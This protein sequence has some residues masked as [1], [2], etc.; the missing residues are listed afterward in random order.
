MWSLF[1]TVLL[2]A[3][4][5]C[6]VVPF[7]PSVYRVFD[8]TAH[9]VRGIKQGKPTPNLL[10]GVDA[11]GYGSASGLYPATH[12]YRCNAVRLAVSNGS[13][14][15]VVNIQLGPTLWMESPNR[16]VEFTA[17]SCRTFLIE[18]TGQDWPEHAE[19]LFL[20]IYQLD[21]RNTPQFRRALYAPSLDAA[22]EMSVAEHMR[23]NAARFMGSDGI[24]PLPDFITFASRLDPNL[25]HVESTEANHFNTGGC[26]VIATWFA[27]ALGVGSVL[28]WSLGAWRIVSRRH[29]RSQSAPIAV[30][31]SEEAVTP[32]I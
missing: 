9:V 24:R 23:A 12:V 19:K 16:R 22:A 5:A 14:S 26:A 21:S 1:C 10:I 6:Y 17:E 15:R 7:G 32:T 18:A 28:L 2:V 31:T 11:S 27:I 25:F 4:I 8:H 20:A 29:W 30:A 3:T 13:T